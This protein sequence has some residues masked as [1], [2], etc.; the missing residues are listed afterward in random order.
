MDERVLYRGGSPKS[1]PIRY[2]H[3]PANNMVWAENAISQYFGN[4]I[5]DFTATHRHLH[6][7]LK[8]ETSIILQDRYWRG[9][10]HGD[11]QS[12]PHARYMTPMCERVS[13][14][15]DH[16]KLEPNNIVLFMP[17]L[18]WETSR[19]REYIASEIDNIVMTSDRKRAEQ[20]AN[21]KK[22]RQKDR[23]GLYPDRNTVQHEQSPPITQVNK[24][25]NFEEAVDEV[26]RTSSRAPDQVNILQPLKG[27]FRPKNALGR[28]LLAAARLS[29]GMATYRDKILLRTYL[30]CD[31]PI[32]PRRTLDQAFYWTLK[33]TKKRDKD[34]VVYRGTTTNSIDV[35]RYDEEKEEWPDHEGLKR[36]CE[37]CLAN[38]RKLSRVVMVDQL[39]MWV[40]DESTII[41]CF[42]KRYGSNK[43]DYYAG[44]H[45]SIR[46]RVEG[47]PYDSIRTVF[48]LAIIILDECTLTFFDRAKY[49]SR[50]PRVLDEFSKA[51]GNIMN[52]QTSAFN[53]LWNWTAEARNIFR[54][55][56]YINTTDLH[57]P[58]LDINP[59]GKLERE[60]EDIIEELDILLSIAN[61]HKD[62]V[63]SFIDQAK[64][65]LDPTGQLSSKE[66]ASG[67]VQDDMTKAK[68][69]HSFHHRAT[70]CQDRVDNHV[71]SLL[72][73]RTSAKNTADD[74]QNLLT[75]KQQQ[76]G[77]VQAWQAVKQSEESI[78]QGRSILVFTL[79]TIVFLPLSFISSVFGM[80]NS[81]FGSNKWDVRTQILYI[82]T[83]SAGFVAIS[84]LFAFSS[85]VRAL[86]WTIY[87][88]V[89]TVVVV[90]TR[91]YDVILTYVKPTRKLV[92]ETFKFKDKT[93]M[94]TKIRV[95]KRR[96]KRN[97]ARSQ[98]RTARAVTHKV[99]SNKA[100]A[101]QKW[102]NVARD[103]RAKIAAGNRK[104]DYVDPEHGC[105][106]QP[107][108]KVS[109]P[110]P[111][112][113]IE[114]SN[115]P[116]SVSDPQ[117]SSIAPSSV[118]RNGD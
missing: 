4:D 35:H 103:A 83:I 74:V 81:D 93:T 64:H 110:I 102:K 117:G 30:P 52:K 46:T 112:P 65:I 72:A 63:Q 3:L 57:V 86:V 101:I 92:D 84:L 77:V 109:T 95:L 37:A 90:K 38:I 82:F 29:E 94:E 39:W 56:G 14:S 58:L 87:H 43:N 17:Y 51:I 115:T 24:I 69:W 71:K 89:S 27:F 50:Q 68:N 41:T 1:N 23:E 96:Q 62:I 6:R 8:T 26:V 73:L 107:L 53:R 70:D 100:W 105:I 45:K 7:T 15:P 2:F 42:P 55:Q 116:P 76:A 85:W 60:I 36:D 54:S 16:A 31:P 66:L 40:L 5:P 44:V 113:T 9:Q 48:D 47:A 49:S 25:E 118:R 11:S 22:S 99:Q 75:M 34:Q 61:I 106:T 67:L 33:S 10:L 108:G 80:N 18:H 28:Y 97:A 78:K 21:D 12:P 104:S 32:H 19:R 114:L 13:S 20:E 79:V 98:P 111:V 91:I 59:E 88:R